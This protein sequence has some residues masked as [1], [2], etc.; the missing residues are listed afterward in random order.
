M[1]RFIQILSN[2]IKCIEKCTIAIFLFKLLVTFLYN[3]D[4]LR[5]NNKK[6][7]WWF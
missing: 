4:L 5:L 6:A 3:F 7:T 2:K 1:K